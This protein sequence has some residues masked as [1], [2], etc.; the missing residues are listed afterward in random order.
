MSF[1]DLERSVLVD[2]FRDTLES[3]AEEDQ[4]PVIDAF[5]NQPVPY[6]EKILKMMVLM[7]EV[8]YNDPF[9]EYAGDGVSIDY[10]VNIERF[11][12]ATQKMLA[13]LPTMSDDALNTLFVTGKLL[14]KD[15]VPNDFAARIIMTQAT[16][17][18]DFPINHL[19][20]KLDALKAMPPST[21]RDMAL[22]DAVFEQIAQ[23]TIVHV[24]M[25][26]LS[27]LVPGA[28]YEHDDD[29][30]LFMGQQNR[31]DVWHGEKHAEVILRFGDQP[32]DNK[33]FPMDVARNSPGDFSQASEMIQQSQRPA[34]KR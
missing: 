6:Q 26:T 28:R 16:N 33:A 3:M 34:L 22:S 23:H 21:E 12:P 25:P 24:E 13:Q 11:E 27:N 29:T 17:D 5:L 31:F 20:R 1:K 15:D 7:D 9:L 10:A 8:Y 19:V 2:Y 32:Q 30:H 14:M 4:T 18:P